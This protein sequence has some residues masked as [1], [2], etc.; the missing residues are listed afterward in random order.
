[1]LY[2]IDDIVF[3]T[4][5]GEVIDQSFTVSCGKN[6]AKVVDANSTEG[7]LVIHETFN[8]VWLKVSSYAYELND[9]F[10]FCSDM[11]CIIDKLLLVVFYIIFSIKTV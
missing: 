6:V 5:E 4:I 9:I 8:G 3:V 10:I 2:F 1:M 11:S 7:L